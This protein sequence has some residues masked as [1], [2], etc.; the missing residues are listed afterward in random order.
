MVI[1][2]VATIAFYI[3]GAAILKPSGLKP[4]DDD[5]IRTLQSMY[6]PVFSTYAPILFMFGAFAVLYSTYFV[7]NA[8]HARTFTDALTVMG[9]LK[10]DP[11]IVSYTVR[12]LSFLFP[13]LCCAI[14]WIWPKTVFLVLLS[15]ATQA[16][17]LPMLGGAALYFRYAK[18]IPE[19]RPTKLWDVFLI[20]SF[21]VLLV[22]GTYSLFTK[23]ADL[24]KFFGLLVNA[25]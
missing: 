7:A 23:G 17:M 18:C 12:Y 25:A 6:E 10:R 20:S 13:L 14:Y 5:L 19:I 11:V 16:I 3:L 15:G 1:Y 4:N 24:L 2:T 21:V 8:S 9:L 22:I